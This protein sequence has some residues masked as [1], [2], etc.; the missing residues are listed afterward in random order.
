MKG[1][2]LDLLKGAIVKSRQKR[3]IVLSI[4]LIGAVALGTTWSGIVSARGLN[5]NL[6]PGG[7]FQVNSMDECL[8]ISLSGM[9]NNGD[10]TST[11]VY[12]VARQPCDQEVNFVLVEIPACA[13]VASAAPTPFQVVFPDPD[14][15][16]DGV[17]WE[18]TPD[19]ESGVFTVVFAGS[20]REGEANAG[21]GA[22]GVEPVSVVIDGPECEPFTA[23]QTQSDTALPIASATVSDTEVVTPAVTESISV[24][25][26]L[27][28]TEETPVEATPTMA[29]TL[30]QIE[31]VTPDVAVT[32]APIESATATDTASLV[33]TPISLPTQAKTEIPLAVNP[34]TSQLARSIMTVQH[35]AESAQNLTLNCADGAVVVSGDSNVLNIEGRCGILVLHGDDNQIKL[36]NPSLIANSGTGNVV[37]VFGPSVVPITGPGGFGLTPVTATPSE[38]PTATETSTPS[39]T[40]SS[41]PTS[42]LSSTP[43]STLTSTPISTLNITPTPQVSSTPAVDSSSTPETSPTP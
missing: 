42:M 32:P 9:T 15:N 8:D 20:L 3:L 36:V 19:F 33:E 27:A 14:L 18:L 40:P 11:W 7:L 30:A 34:S 13:M 26:T 23:L 17:K 28:A 4:L 25:E 22:P 41:T 31:S 2:I 29:V 35:I 24:T 5:L 1:K 6:G 16:V 10:G 38:T 37:S 39:L 43:T 21:L 12:S